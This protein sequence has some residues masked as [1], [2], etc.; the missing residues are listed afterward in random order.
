MPLPL[1]LAS[2]AAGAYQDST[3]NLTKNILLG[4]T[5]CKT[6]LILFYYCIDQQV[7]EVMKKLE[8]I[9]LHVSWLNL[10]YPCSTLLHHNGQGEE[11]RVALKYQMTSFHGGKDTYNIADPICDIKNARVFLTNLIIFLH[12]FIIT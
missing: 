2:P 5:Y 3:S 6:L 11:K 12:R 8:C 9:D 4:Q 1:V 7:I 10:K